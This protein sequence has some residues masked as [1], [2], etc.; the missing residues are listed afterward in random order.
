MLKLV[1]S[2]SGKRDGLGVGSCLS[3]VISCQLVGSKYGL[4]PFHTCAIISVTSL[5]L[6]QSESRKLDIGAIVIHNGSLVA[7]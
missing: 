3:M 1:C 6:R 4:I 2:L 5:L 7:M